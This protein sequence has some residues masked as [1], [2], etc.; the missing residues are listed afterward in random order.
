[1]STTATATIGRMARSASSMAGSSLYR[2]SGFIMGAMVGNAVLGFAYWTVIAHTARP[3][4]VGL[5]AGVVAALTLTALLAN[6][7][8]GPLMIQVLPSLEDDAS[9][10]AFVTAGM[11]A[12][13][14][15][16]TVIGV[17]AAVVLPLVS[18]N[19][20]VLR[21][22]EMFV[23]F[24]LGSGLTAVSIGLDAVFVASRSSGGMLARN[25]AFG[26]G[27]IVLVLAAVPVVARVG[28]AWIVATW[29]LGLAGAVLY[30]VTK[31]IPKVRPGFSL[32]IHGGMG[33]VL[34][35]WRLML[36]HHLTNLGGVLVQ[37]ILPVLV[38]IRLTPRSN[39]FFY[40]TWNVG[41][42]FFLVSASITTSL[43]AE[44]AHGAHLRD[45]TRRSILLIAGVLA[46][47]IIV[48]VACSHQILGV[49]GRQ[50]AV[51]GSALLV[52]LAVAAVPDAITNVAVAVLRV[53]QRIHR[54]AQLNLLMAAVAVGL[55]WILLPHLGILA[56]GIAWGIG[57]SIGAVAVGIGV[58][59]ARRSPRLAAA[60][61]AGG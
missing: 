33:D 26:A 47:V 15:I 23:L 48:T 13:A 58:L 44:G 9:W 32:R 31:L 21:N 35:R 8:I 5:A 28:S 50:Y 42:I 10:S 29:V 40:L 30:G 54:A 49:F 3:H 38:V 52:V 4:E 60:A 11:L 24:A 12:T 34:A 2:N 59:T 41:A 6:L 45:N 36:G 56:P 25:T 57:Q 61:G 7:G 53:E 20:V 51:N 39:A 1:M 16:S 46:P 17:I 14:C 22:P 27:K 19:L 55:T 37:Y 18:P 43:F